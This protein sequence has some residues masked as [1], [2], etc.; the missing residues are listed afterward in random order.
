MQEVDKHQSFLYKQATATLIFV[1]ERVWHFYAMEN[2]FL[3][4]LYVRPLSSAFNCRT[5]GEPKALPEIAGPRHSQLPG[6]W[7]KATIIPLK[8]LDK[9]DYTAV[10]ERRPISLLS[11]LGK[12]LDSVVA[13]RISHAV[14]TL[15]PASHRSLECQ[16]EALL[17]TR[18]S[19]YCKNTSTTH[20]GRERSSA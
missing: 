11:T 19:C 1:Y 8:K 16:E 18:R 3:C 6:K 17:R 14:E 5:R 4:N 2:N 13:E 12:A 9:G 15:G 7:R 10:K 20:G